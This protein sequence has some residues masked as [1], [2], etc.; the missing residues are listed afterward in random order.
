MERKKKVLVPRQVGV[1]RIEKNLLV[2]LILTGEAGL[3]DGHPNLQRAQTGA[4]FANLL[5]FKLGLIK[6]A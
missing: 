4:G 1:G 3:P 5:C 2:L 6:L